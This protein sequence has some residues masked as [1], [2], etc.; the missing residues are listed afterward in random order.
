MYLKESFSV[1]QIAHPEI[2]VKFTAFTKLRPINVLLLKDQPA[3]QCKCKIHEN[4]MFKFKVL[5]GYNYTNEFWKEN[6]FK[7]DDYTSD[8]WKGDCTE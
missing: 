7:S 4:F 3:D 8:C 2:D 1:F 5:A 6:L